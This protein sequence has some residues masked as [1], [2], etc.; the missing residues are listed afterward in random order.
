[1]SDSRSDEEIR[2][3][4]IKNLKRKQEFW[5]LLVLFTLLSGLFVA[6]WWFTI[7]KDGGGSAY[8]WPIWPM[9]GFVIALVAT[10][11]D[12][13]SS[14]FGRLNESKIQKE[15]DKLKN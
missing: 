8:F 10:G 7:G 5:K 4:A 11:I 1:M 9:L 13:F 12:A 14:G 2:K 6:I 3:Q 15:I